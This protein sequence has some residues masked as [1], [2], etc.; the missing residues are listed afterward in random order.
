MRHFSDTFLDSYLTANANDVLS[1]VGG[2]KI[3]GEGIQLFDKID[4]DA[5]TI[6]GIPLLPLLEFLRARKLLFS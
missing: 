6:Q 5:F 3:E 1:C 4:G 2:Y